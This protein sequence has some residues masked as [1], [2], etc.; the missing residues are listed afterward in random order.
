MRY[1][2]DGIKYEIQPFEIA[3][4]TLRAV[5]TA[6]C[7]KSKVTDRVDLY[8]SHARKSFCQE[9]GKKFDI[10]GE[11]MVSTICIR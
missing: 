7:E 10:D 9:C 5:I 2:I 3:S 11:G 6:E 4:F 1:E 8:V